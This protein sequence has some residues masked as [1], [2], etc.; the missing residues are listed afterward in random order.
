ML[1]FETKSMKLSQSSATWGTCSMPE[2]AVS[3]LRSHAVNM[4]RASSANTNRH[5]PLLTRDKVYSSCVRSVMLHAAETC[6]MKVITLNGLQP[7]DRTMIH[8][9]RNVRA[10]DEVSLDSLITTLGIQNLD[11]VLCTSRVRWFVHVQHKHSTGW[12][13]EVHTLDMAAQKISGTP[14]KSWNKVL[15][16]RHEKTSFLHMRKQRCRSAS[17]LPKFISSYIY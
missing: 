16:P 6:S 17:R 4:H 11:V 10:K 1:R 9:I 7:N 3:W 14:R 2:L 5:L 8:W 12:I 15:E 13:A